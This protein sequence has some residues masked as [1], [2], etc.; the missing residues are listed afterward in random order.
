MSSLAY[1]NPVANKGAAGFLI[2]QA[3]ESADSFNFAL[4]SFKVLV[5][6]LPPP[7]F[8]IDKDFTE[9]TALETI[10]PQSKILYCSF[11][12]LKWIK[13]VIQTARRDNRHLME[14]EQKVIDDCFRKF[15][16]NVK[17]DVEEELEAEL[18]D[19]ICDVEVRVGT[20]DM[21]KYQD[22]EEYYNNKW[23]NCKE[24]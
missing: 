1:V 7:I 24:K 21:E 14:E 19:S 22:L 16:Y 13:T 2:F 18:R 17:E 11:H 3:D 8:V 20:R 9:Q 6:K 23:N 10:F 12:V 15:M 5:E 4:K